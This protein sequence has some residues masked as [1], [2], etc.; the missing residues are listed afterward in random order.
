MGC[1]ACC[2]GISGASY[3]KVVRSTKCGRHTI[4]NPFVLQGPLKLKQHIHQ[5]GADAVIS[6]SGSVGMVWNVDAQDHARVLKNYYVGVVVWGRI[7]PK[8]G[9]AESS[10]GL[11]HLPHVASCS[12]APVRSEILSEGSSN[13]GVK[14]DP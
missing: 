9:A 10:P 13:V 12:E 3:F 6:R 5:T 1:S 7:S 8:I 4:N 2:R 14:L 11:N